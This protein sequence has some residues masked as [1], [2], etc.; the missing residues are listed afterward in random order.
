MAGMN[1]LLTG[2]EEWSRL[3]D[4]DLQLLQDSVLTLIAVFVLF[5]AGSYFLFNP[6]RAF[7]EKRKQRIAD[8][9]QAAK[10]DKE[11]ARRL[12]EEYEEKLKNVD[13]KV[14]EILSDARKKAVAN[15]EKTVNN[16]YSEADRII[17]NANHEAALEKQR[18][19]NEVKDE[20]VTVASAMAGKIVENSMDEETKKR[21]LDETLKEMGESTWLN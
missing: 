4:L 6:V 10:D 20:I 3:F 1:L 9:I 21:L 15:A 13:S 17:G 7:L 16:A 5:L 11:E 18:V 19:A 8:D 12:K 14:E 2:G